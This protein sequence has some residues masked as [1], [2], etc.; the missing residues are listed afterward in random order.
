MLTAYDAMTA[1]LFDEAG[2]EVL[3]VGDSV[4]NTV[5]GHSSTLPVTLDQMIL[6]SQAVV[7]GAQRALVV[8]DLP[9]GSYEA[10]PPAGRG[11]GGAPREG[12]RRARREGGG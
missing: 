8:A 12:V 2:I 11:V 5:L 7:R 3:L 9:F 1:A 6:F 10:S 4:G